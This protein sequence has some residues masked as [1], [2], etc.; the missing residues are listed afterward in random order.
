MKRR[1]WVQAMRREVDETAGTARFRWLLGIAWVGALGLVAP[2]VATGVVVGVAGGAVGNRE[3]FL[4]VYRGGSNSWMGALALTLPTAL[5][6]IVA[7][8]LVLAR[9]RAGM[10]AA[11]SFAALVGVSAV[12]SVTNAPPVGPFLTDWKHVTVD[13]HATDHADELRLNSAI[14]A[15]AA[16]TA[17][18]LVAQRRRAS[19][20]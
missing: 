3:V 8:L 6:G 12:I 18:V 9:H 10:A 1:E 7:A 4:E 11:Y 17:L 13:P 14:G 16:A 20:T 5:A 2:L 15:V 19:S